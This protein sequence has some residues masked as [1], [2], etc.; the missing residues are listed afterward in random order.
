VLPGR[1]PHHRL[2]E[3]SLTQHQMD[4]S[5][6]RN[7]TLTV[8]PLQAVSGSYRMRHLYVSAR[9]PEGAAAMRLTLDAIA[10]AQLVFEYEPHPA[11]KP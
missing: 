1:G 6:T 7:R 2:G 9:S 10:S 11:K 8:P 3:G 5:W 4:G